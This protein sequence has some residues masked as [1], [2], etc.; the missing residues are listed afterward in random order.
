MFVDLALLALDVA[1]VLRLHL[2][3]Q[4]DLLPL[5]RSKAI[6]PGAGADC[7]QARDISVTE[8]RA[9]QQVGS[10]ALA[11]QFPA[12]DLLVGGA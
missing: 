11:L 3:L 8:L 4:V 6:A 7:R 5:L 12:E 2:E 9:P 10:A 1:C